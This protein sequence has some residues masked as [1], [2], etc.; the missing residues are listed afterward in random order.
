MGPLDIWGEVRGHRPRPW[1]GSLSSGPWFLLSSTVRAMGLM[2]AHGSIQ[3]C[4]SVISSLAWLSPALEVGGWSGWES[5]HTLDCSA[6]CDTIPSTVTNICIFKVT[7]HSVTLKTQMWFFSSHYF[8]NDWL[9]YSS[10]WNSTNQVE[11]NRPKRIMRSQTLGIRKRG[12]EG[13]RLGV[14]VPGQGQ[15][16]ES[17]W[18]ECELKSAFKSITVPTHCSLRYTL[19]NCGKYWVTEPV[20]SIQ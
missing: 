5:H 1:A 18:W 10:K 2:S 16:V 3:P 11:M 6:L 14:M 8:L 20:L 15:R 17:L 12:I 13:G 7:P 4:A 9:A 19:K